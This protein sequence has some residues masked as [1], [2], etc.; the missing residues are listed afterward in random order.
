MTV[1]EGDRC[2][3]RRRMVQR[4]RRHNH[5]VGRRCSM[6]ILREFCSRL[7]LVPT[8]S[9]TVVALIASLFVIE[10]PAGAAEQVGFRAHS[11]QGF[12]TIGSLTAEKPESKL[13]Y[14][15]GSWWAAMLVP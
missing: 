13:W 7:K 6:S 3:G 9:V 5:G 11:I 14:H 10:R 2:G 8:L 1:I 4:A 15:D 12:D